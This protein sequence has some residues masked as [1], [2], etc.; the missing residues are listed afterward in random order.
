VR[1]AVIAH[2]ECGQP[3]T[4]SS[5]PDRVATMR[6]TGA[7]WASH[8]RPPQGMCGD[9]RGRDDPV[10]YRAG[11]QCP[12][13]NRL[14]RPDSGGVPRRPSAAAARHGRRENGSTSNRTIMAEVGVTRSRRDGARAGRG[15]PRSL[16]RFHQHPVAVADVEVSSIGRPGPGMVEDEVG[17]HARDRGIGAIHWGDPRA[18][19]VRQVKP[20]TASCSSV[21]ASNSSAWKQPAGRPAG[22]GEASRRGT[23]LEGQSPGGAARGDRRRRVLSRVYDAALAPAPGSVRLLMLHCP[24]YPIENQD[25]RTGAGSG[26]PRP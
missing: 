3:R 5:R 2:G 22:G 7:A 10:Q 21:T 15:S 13:R 25:I 16:C 14:P 1:G 4:R 12:A 19:L 17:C 20:A 26:W 11:K 9:P 6:A 24:R 8:P 18:V 23:G